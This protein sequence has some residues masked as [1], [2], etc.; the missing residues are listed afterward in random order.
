MQSPWIELC[1]S[2]S[3]QKLISQAEIYAK[4]DWPVMILGESG[5]GKELFARHIHLCS[6]RRHETFAPLNCGAVPQGLFESELFGYEKG[7]FTGAMQSYRGI[8]RSAHGGTVFLDEVGDLDLALQVKLLRVLDS[9]EVRPVGGL[10][11]EEIN[12]RWITATNVDLGLAISEKAFRWD[13]YERLAVLVLNIPPLRER[14]EDI[15]CLSHYFLKNLGISTDEKSRLPLLDYTWPGNVR[16][17]KNFL[18]RVSLAVKPQNIDSRIKELLKE[19][20]ARF[21]LESL[22]N[23]NS[24]SGSLAE[25]EKG[26]ILDRLEKCG[27]N[28]KATARELGIAKSTLHEKL[29]RWKKENRLSDPATYSEPALLAN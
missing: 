5:V 3:F 22:V 7:A 10:R 13:L 2:P 8:T 29:R 27:G 25:I 23:K 11:C 12:V 20:S 18:T 1:P 14:K 21:P 28:R 6:P 16:Q 9:G 17:L 26:V 15:L 24:G 19:E 4:S